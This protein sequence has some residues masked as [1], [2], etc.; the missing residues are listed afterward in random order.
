MSGGCDGYRHDRCAGC[1]EYR[2]TYMLEDKAT[3][4]WHRAC[5]DCREFALQLPLLTY[6][7]WRACRRAEVRGL[8]EKIRWNSAR[9][10]VLN[11]NS[12]VGRE[13]QMDHDDA[14]MKLARLA[15]EK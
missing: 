2:V 14:L 11:P 1:G 10:S 6:S 3:N 9:I 12:D 4:R 15:E 7:I 8:V 5:D 13:A